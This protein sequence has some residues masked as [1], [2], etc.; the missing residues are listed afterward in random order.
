MGLSEQIVEAL[1]ARN[2][3]GETYERIS[4]ASGVA[5]SYIHRLANNQASPLKMSLEKFLAL[6]PDVQIEVDPARY[7]SR[8]VSSGEFDRIIQQVEDNKREMA[9]MRRMLQ[10]LTGNPPQPPWMRYKDEPAAPYRVSGAKSISFSN[11]EVQ[12]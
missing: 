5:A 10:E 11:K 3:S 8:T 12:K 6:F 7:Q 1:R 2:K 4:R 9:E